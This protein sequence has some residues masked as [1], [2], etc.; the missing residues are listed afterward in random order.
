M[1]SSSADFTAVVLRRNVPEA[2]SDVALG[3]GNFDSVE[4]GQA[5]GIVLVQDR[6]LGDSEILGQMFDPGLGLLKIGSANIDDVAAIRIA[7]ELCARERADERNFGLGRDR[8]AGIRRRGSD[9][10]DDRQYFVF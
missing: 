8:Q 4:S 3:H 9:R 6:Y 1:I 10:T 2:T 5:E 7:E